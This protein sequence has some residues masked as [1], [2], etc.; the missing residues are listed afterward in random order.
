MDLTLKTKDDVRLIK[1]FMPFIKDGRTYKEI[2]KEMRK[3]HLDKYI[4]AMFGNYILQMIN[5]DIEQRNKRTV[6]REV[7]LLKM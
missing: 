7:D 3:R 2:R 1:E 5:I 6:W 4:S